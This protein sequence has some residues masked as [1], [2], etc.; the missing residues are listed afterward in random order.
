MERTVP[1]GL[2]ECPNCS[3]QLG[4]QT[5]Q[6]ERNFKEYGYPNPH[7]ILEAISSS[8]LHYMAEKKSEFGNETVEGVGRVPGSLFLKYL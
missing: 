6:F 1:R 2:T 4:V 8:R 5:L 7:L 3:K